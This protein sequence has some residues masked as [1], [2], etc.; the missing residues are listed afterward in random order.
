MLL[1]LLPTERIKRAG[2]GRF[3]VGDNDGSCSG[4]S[5]EEKHSRTDNY[6]KHNTVQ[7][8]ERNE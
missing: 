7:G 2:D 8:K 5:N 3:A 1:L 4:C 6:K